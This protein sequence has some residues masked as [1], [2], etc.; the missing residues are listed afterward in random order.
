MY[1]IPLQIKYKDT[2]GV[3]YG[4]MREI[5]ILVKP[6]PEF[7]IVSFYTKP[8]NICRG[9]HVVLHVKIRNAGSEEG[10]SI[11]VRSTGEAEVP[12]DFDVKSDYVGNLKVGEERDAILE[13]DVDEDASLKTYQQ[14]L[15]IR[16]TGDRDLG[17]DNVYTFDKQVS[18]S[19]SSH[20]P[21]GFSL[22][23]GISVPGFEALLSLFALLLV[24]VFI[25]M[26]RKWD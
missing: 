9:D 7:E 13:F 4:V 6:K 25:R 22:P 8:A 18:I 23:G 1:S 20:C 3:E 11:S 15:E 24:F 21:E 2:K 10:E 16:C 19:V 12:F 14:K 5:N 26:R 17:D